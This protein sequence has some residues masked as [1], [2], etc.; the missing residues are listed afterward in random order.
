MAKRLS[1]EALTALAAAAA[2]A[3]AQGMDADQANLAADFLAAVSQNLSLIAARREKEEE[4]GAASQ[5]KEG[6]G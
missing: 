3:F 1:G 5:T 2:A 6:G 4:S